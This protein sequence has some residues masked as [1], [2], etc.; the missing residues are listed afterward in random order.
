MK[1]VRFY[2]HSFFYGNPSRGRAAAWLFA[3][4]ASALVWLIGAVSLF[5]YILNTPYLYDGW[6]RGSVAMSPQTALGFLLT[7]SALLFIHRAKDT[8]L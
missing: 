2:L 7:G 5:G 3:D 1:Y 8:Q 4:A 6:F